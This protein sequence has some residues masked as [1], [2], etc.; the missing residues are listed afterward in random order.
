MTRL[1][2]TVLHTPDG[3]YIVVRG[4]LWRSSNPDLSAAERQRLVDD[5]M[6]AR[7]RVRSPDAEAKAKARRDVDRAKQALGERGPVWW[8][9]G[10]PD[11]NRHLAKNTPYAAWYAA[12]AEDEFR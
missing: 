2:Q 5:L 8:T 3:R 7:R 10:A 4:R 1:T 9:D 12:V 11:Y 6:D